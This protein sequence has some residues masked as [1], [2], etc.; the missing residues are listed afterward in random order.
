M[1]EPIAESTVHLVFAHGSGRIG[2]DAF[3]QQA[4]AFPDAEFPVLPGYGDDEPAVADV[5]VAAQR[6]ALLATEADALV[7]FTYGGVVAALAACMDHANALVLIE[8]AL[9]GLARDR[10]ANRA[11]IDRLEP[12]YLNSSLTD[13]GF[14]RAFLRELQGADPGELLE[15]GALSWSRRTRLHGAPWRHP[16]DPACLRETP[17]LVLTG[18]WNDEYEEVAA[19]LVELGAE[20][21]VL[22]GHGHRVVDHPECSERIRAFVAAA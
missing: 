10:P 4:E 13:A 1:P 9:F 22:A 2:R 3:P 12:I 5:A 21:A 17:T 15:P 14:G 18:G 16:I 7:G 11:L 19:A 6:L 20:H 8:P